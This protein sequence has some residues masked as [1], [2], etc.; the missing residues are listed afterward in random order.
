MCSGEV[1]SYCSIQNTVYGRLIQA[2][3]TKAVSTPKQPQRIL[4]RMQKLRAASGLCAAEVCDVGPLLSDRARE[5]L[6]FFIG[7]CMSVCKVPDI[8]E[9]Q[10]ADNQAFFQIYR[11]K[12]AK[13][14]ER[15]PEKR[16]STKTKNLQVI[17]DFLISMSVFTEGKLQNEKTKQ[18]GGK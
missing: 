5:A 14:R 7:F 3:G 18:K 2:K 11:Y 13:K 4:H 8:F 10:L 9:H 17:V 12:K 6:I 1:R 15:S 16:P